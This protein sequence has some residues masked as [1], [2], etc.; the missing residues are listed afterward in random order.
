MNSTIKT[1]I[2]N[3]AGVWKWTATTT[4]PG[5]PATT[6]TIAGATAHQIDATKQLNQAANIISTTI[7]NIYQHDNQAENS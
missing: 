6:I 3:H 4:K 5:N 2:K 7:E 1:S